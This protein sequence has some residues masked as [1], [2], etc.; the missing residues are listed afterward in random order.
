MACTTCLGRGVVPDLTPPS[1]P[2]VPFP[3][4]EYHDCPACVGA[5]L[6]KC[7]KCGRFIPF[8]QLDF[9]TICDWCWDDPQNFENWEEFVQRFKQRKGYEQTEVGWRIR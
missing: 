3:E 5:D 8:T 6:P 2:N 4:V 9:C 1:G 7:P